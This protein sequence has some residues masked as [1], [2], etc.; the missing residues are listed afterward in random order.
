MTEKSFSENKI[1]MYNKTYNVLFGISI[2]ALLI[3]IGAV[4]L[5]Y[6]LVFKHYN[7][8][9]VETIN[10]IA[11]SISYN[12]AKSTPLGVFYVALVGG[13]FFVYIPLEVMLGKFFSAGLP[14]FIVLGIYMF[15]VL[16]SYSLDY[17]IGLRLSK[18][19]KKMISPKKFYGIKSR[20]N[21]FGW[22]LIYAFNALPLP[23][24]ILA[25]ILGVFRYNKARFY[26][27]FILGQLTKVT[28]V[29]LGISLFS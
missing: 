2:I 8:P 28:V 23:S 20:I 26:I 1:F 11:N 15:G 13:L 9:W 18:L 19:L 21:K 7:L 10:N 5:L 25:A 17:Y 6:L 4:F 22:V 3:V 16:I 27:F 29:Y 14:F 12:I 24:Q